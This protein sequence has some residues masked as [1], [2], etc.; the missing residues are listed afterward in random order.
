MDSEGTC[1]SRDSFVSVQLSAPLAALCGG[2]EQLSLCGILRGIWAHVLSKQLLLL[3]PE[4]Q[5]TLA[6]KADE[7]GGSTAASSGSKKRDEPAKSVVGPTVD[8]SGIL[9]ART[10]TALQAVSTR[11]FSL[12][13]SLAVPTYDAPLPVYFGDFQ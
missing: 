8:A 13:L 6:G 5:A 7:G 11:A 12:G 10:D 4:S 9:H 1:Q 2:H 3:P